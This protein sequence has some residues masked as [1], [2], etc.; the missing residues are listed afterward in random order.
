MSQ[1]RYKWTWASRFRTSPRSG[2]RAWPAWKPRAFPQLGLA[3]RRR[4][5]RRGPPGP[6]DPRLHGRRRL[7]GDDDPLA[8][9]ERLPHAPRRHPRQRRLLR[10]LL[11]RLE[12]RLE[13]SRR[14][15][16]RVAIIG[17]SRGGI[18]A[19]V[20]AARRPDLVSGIVTLGSPTVSQLSA[21]PVVLAHILLVGA[22][23]TGRVPG[24]FR[25]SCLRG[26]CC[27]RFRADLVGDFP[28]RGRLHRAVLAHRR[29]RRL[30]RLPGPR[31]GPGRG[32]RVAP[33]DGPQRRGLRRGRP[34]ARHVRATYW[35][36]AA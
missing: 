7:A 31:R 34:R 16:A 17:Q 14:A 9:R 30:A 33:R 22:L 29:R 15:R 6:A 24:M 3:R 10:G 35:A 1:I 20:L 25:M 11:Q 12:Q 8:A 32:P 21:H 18:F 36:E 4:A 2:A 28:R 27:E 5:R 13:G 19:R 26:A 23:G